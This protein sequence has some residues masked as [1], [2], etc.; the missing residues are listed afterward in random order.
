MYVSATVHIYILASERVIGL[1][2]MHVRKNILGFSMVR[3][4]S[5]FNYYFCFGALVVH[6]GF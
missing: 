6:L 3:Q 1:N 2:F 5:L 4:N